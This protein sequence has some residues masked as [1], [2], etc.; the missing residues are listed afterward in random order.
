VGEKFK[1]QLE[2][3]SLKTIYLKKT[4]ESKNMILQKNRHLEIFWTLISVVVLH[5]EL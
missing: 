5:N 3:K 4:I 1:E 2:K